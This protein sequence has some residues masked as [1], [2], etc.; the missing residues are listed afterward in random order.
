MA[1]EFDGENDYIK[2]T[3][4][5]NYDVGNNSLTLSI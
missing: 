5:D 3:Y 2:T 4:G 1:Y